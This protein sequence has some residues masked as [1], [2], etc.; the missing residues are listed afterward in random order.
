M[1]IRTESSPN[2]ANMHTHQ[3]PQ[4]DKLGAVFQQILNGLKGNGVPQQSSAQNT[5]AQIRQLASQTPHSVAAANKVDNLLAS[6]ESNPAD[7]NKAL[8]GLN[9]QELVAILNRPKAQSLLSAGPPRGEGGPSETYVTAGTKEE[10]VNQLAQL[11]FTLKYIQTHPGLPDNSTT[12]VS[13]IGGA[14]ANV[15]ASSY[16]QP[17]AVNYIVNH[18]SESQLNVVLT[19]AAGEKIG[20]YVS[21]YNNPPPPGYSYQPSRLVSILNAVSNC[22]S[23]SCKVKVFAAVATGPFSNMFSNANNPFGISNVPEF[24]AVRQALTGLLES[25]PQGIIQGLVIDMQNRALS[26]NALTTYISVLLQQGKTGLEQVNQLVLQLKFGLD[27]NRNNPYGYI[28]TQITNPGVGSTSYENAYVLGFFVGCV[29]HIINQTV[30]NTEAKQH[31]TD[32]LVTNVA[33]LVRAIPYPGFSQVGTL[34]STFWDD[35]SSALETDE[36]DNANEYNEAIWQL[37]IIAPETTN[38]YVTATGIRDAI[39][40]GFSDAGGT[41]PVGVQS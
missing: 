26:R 34:G 25:D 36:T 21:G 9:A 5:L 32:L 37:A 19:S 29:D 22:G 6:L 39:N 35:Y 15:L 23:V 13:P 2:R 24:S 30:G 33:A 41:L 17:D 4:S 27:P 3:P 18:L 14:V 28:N 38:G 1:T 16:G 8:Q 11:K 40:N 31:Q 7:L 20:S 10:M 12:I